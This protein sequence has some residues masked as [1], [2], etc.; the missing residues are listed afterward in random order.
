VGNLEAV[1]AADPEFGDAAARPP[2]M[3]DVA[4]LAGVSHQTV[5]R[6]LNNKDTV[7]GATRNRVLAAM[8]ELGYR[9]NIAA[10]ALVTG[11][12]R[13]LGVVSLDSTLFGPASTLYEIERATRDAGYF[14]SIASIRSLDRSSVEAA[15][16]HLMSQ[17]VEGIVIIAPLLSA[18]RA[19]DGLPK[20]LPVVVVEGE[21][22]I[23]RATVSVDQE[24][25]GRLA[26]GHLLG[27]GHRTV[28]HVAGPSDWTE[29]RGRTAGWRAALAAAGAEAPP[30][31]AGDWSPR[32]GYE[33][34]RILA[35]VP[36]VTAVFVANDQMSLGVLR[37][38]HE[39]GRRVPEE[40][41]IVGFD[42]ISEAAYF[43]PPLTTVRQDFGA[44][45]RRSLQLLVDQIGSGRIT[46]DRHVVPPELKLRDSTA[47]A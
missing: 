33:A 29:A 39:H 36:E 9:P 32:S 25:G 3:Q 26:T 45:G 4:R 5:S 30:P 38:L 15:V 31:L 27:R 2:S 28:W 47:D 35:R 44:V 41:S 11:R 7:K 34:G 37:A 46:A 1:P 40:I 18:H 8:R 42:D 24:E 19:L 6:V 17:A 10:R 21:H 14:L 22:D 12:S 13:L 20:G 23:A 43:T 16:G